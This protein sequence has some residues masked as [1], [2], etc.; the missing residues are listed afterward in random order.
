MYGCAFVVPGISIPYL[1]CHQRTGD[2]RHWVPQLLRNYR[3][4]GF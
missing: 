4:T 1:L 3:K 2:A